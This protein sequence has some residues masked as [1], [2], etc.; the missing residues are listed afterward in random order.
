MRTEHHLFRK[1]GAIIET[2]LPLFGCGEDTDE[3][4]KP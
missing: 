3:K 1:N 2:V 4:E